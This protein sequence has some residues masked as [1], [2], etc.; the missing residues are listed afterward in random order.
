[1]AIKGQKAQAQS[2]RKLTAG[3]VRAQRAMVS[4]FAS[5]NQAQANEPITAMKAVPAITGG[6]EE[7]LD[8]L[9]SALNDISYSVEQVINM[10][11]P[12][13]PEYLFAPSDGEEGCIGY[14]TRHNGVSNSNTATVNRI[15]SQIDELDRIQRRVEFLRAHLKV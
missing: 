11:Q 5:A 4:G 13:L 7:A 3:E 2:N 6:T 1:M 8:Y 14:E 10:C 15:N 9:Q 12:H